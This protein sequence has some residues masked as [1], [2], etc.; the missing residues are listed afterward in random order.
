V[1]DILTKNLKQTGVYWGNPA[2][3]GWGGNTFDEAVEIDCRWEDRQELFIDKE[4]NQVLS[5]AVVFTGQDVDLG[6]YLYLGD[7]DDLDS[8]YSDPKIIDGA[9][10]IR[11][12]Q[13]VPDIKG[14]RYQRKVWL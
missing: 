5:Q 11:A 7:L 4:G 6:G 14:T 2:P 9:R 1:T 10:E 12:F 8:D 13:K 3:D